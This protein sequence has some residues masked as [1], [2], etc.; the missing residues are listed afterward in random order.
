LTR[1][2]PTTMRSVLFVSSLVPIVPAIRST[3]SNR[4]LIPAMIARTLSEMSGQTMIAMPH[5][6][7]TRPVAA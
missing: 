2:T 7:E 4:M 5:A 3:L 1:A 6:A